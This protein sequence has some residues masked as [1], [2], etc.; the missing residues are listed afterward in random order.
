[1]YKSNW[2]K[3]ELELNPQNQYSACVLL[4]VFYNSRFIED[5]YLTHKY[6]ITTYGIINNVIDWVHSKK[7]H[8]FWYSALKKINNF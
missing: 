8:Y 3:I 2:S 4:E 7:G 6:S 5:S 1:M